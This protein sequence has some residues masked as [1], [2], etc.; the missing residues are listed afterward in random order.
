ML[1]P[2]SLRPKKI[3][4]KREVLL[5]AL[6]ELD[7]DEEDAETVKMGLSPTDAVRIL[8]TAALIGVAGMA[9]ANGV[10]EMPAK[11]WVIED[12]DACDDCKEIADGGPYPIDTEIIEP[13]PH[14]RCR[15]EIQRR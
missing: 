3:N 15:W 14:C 8:T 4:K 6:D 11:D 7:Y 5:A 13:H 12:G 10:E 2:T 1:T 9:L